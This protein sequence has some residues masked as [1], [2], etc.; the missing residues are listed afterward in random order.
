MIKKLLTQLHNRKDYELSRIVLWLLDTGNIKLMK[1]YVE[2]GY[3]GVPQWAYFHLENTSC[4]SSA[5]TEFYKVGV[6]FKD[7]RAHRIFLTHSMNECIEHK[8][9][10]GLLYLLVELQ[11]VP[12]EKQMNSIVD[13]LEEEEKGADTL[14]H[15][16]LEKIQFEDDG[17]WHGNSSY[18][19]EERHN[20]KVSHCAALP[21]LC[22]ALETNNTK[23]TKLA[24]DT[25]KNLFA[26]PAAFQRI[27]HAVKNM[28]DPETR[29]TVYRLIGPA[30]KIIADTWG[31][32]HKFLSMS[33]FGI[34][35]V[36]GEA[37]ELLALL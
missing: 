16:L 19:P 22:Y 30:A 2:Q 31:E 10:K 15:T 35:E 28:S 13:M 6:L 27:Y 3:V 21:L 1:I 26:E 14:L 33:T 34:K 9:C 12:D 23:T 24:I 32:P 29:D 5:W 18:S 37:N 7:D 11:A 36:I 25:Q 20:L 4:Y 17:E 8:D